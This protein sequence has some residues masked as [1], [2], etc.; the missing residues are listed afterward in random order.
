[1][2]TDNYFSSYQLAEYL[3]TVGLT[4]LVTL[5][6][7]KREVP[8]EFVT[9]N[10][11]S[12]S[13]S[14]LFG[15]Q[16]D[17]TMGSLVTKKKKVD[18]LLSTMRDEGIVDKESG[19]PLQ[20]LD[21]NSTKGGIDTVDLMCSSISTSRRTQRWPMTIFFLLLDITGIN[22]LGIYQMN[23]PL[24]KF[25][26]RK[27]LYQL[28]LELMDGN[29]KERAK[30]TNLPKDLNIFLESFRGI[31]EMIGSALQPSENVQPI[32]RPICHICFRKKNHRTQLVCKDCRKHVCKTHDSIICDTCIERS[33]NNDGHTDTK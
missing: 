3:L 23:H 7:N 2:N 16:D 17:K 27:H 21:Y 19:K 30:L 24:M 13:G 8:L 18:L 32:G 12:V 5:R 20:V 26:R 9:K 11:N 4:F 1:M 33:D 22:S 31:P 6:K 28:S 29:L 14:I 25:G 15:C 10:K